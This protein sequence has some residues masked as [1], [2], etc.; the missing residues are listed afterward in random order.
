MEVFKAFLC[1]FPVLHAGQTA[2]WITS[3]LSTAR[4]ILKVIAVCPKLQHLPEIRL[5]TPP[6]VSDGVPAAD[7]LLSLLHRL[8][9]SPPV[10]LSAPPTY[11]RD[12]HRYVNEA[13]PFAMDVWQG[14]QY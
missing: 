7:H 8:G 1:P 12:G 6:T 3:L 10:P 5:H 2:A 14:Y 11:N 13:V 4:V 9:L